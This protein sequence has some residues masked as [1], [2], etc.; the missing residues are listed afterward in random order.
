MN[1]QSETNY[2]GTGC[3]KAA[4]PDLWGSGEVTNRSTRNLF[5]QF[6]K[7]S[8]YQAAYLW[9]THELTTAASI[10]TR[11]GFELTEEKQSNSFGK[12]LKEQRY[13]ISLVH[14]HK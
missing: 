14:L 2:R 4:R 10:Y 13:D 12:T 3:G 11:H 1:P 6:L 8:R 9:T 5:I 7:D